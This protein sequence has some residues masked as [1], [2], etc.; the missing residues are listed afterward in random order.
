MAFIAVILS[1][2]ASRLYAEETAF[3]AADAGISKPGSLEEVVLQLK[4]KHQFQF[5]GYYA[6]VEKGYYAKAGLKVRLVEGGPGLDA[7]SEAAS[8][9]AQYGVS[10]SQALLHR[11]QGQPLVAL[12]AIFQHSP[13]VITAREDAGIST[14]QDLIGKRVKIARNSRDVEL[15]A[16]LMN[17][18]VSLDKIDIIDSW[19]R[20]EDYFDPDI[21][22]LSAYMTN[23]LFY[24][25]QEKI[26]H[27]IINPLVYGIDFYGDCLITSEQEL[28]E[29]P[30][31]V[32]AFLQASLD[33]WAYAMAHPDE[34]IQV[35][36]FKYESEK[37]LEHLQ[38]E[39]DVMRRL[40]MPDLVEIGHMN[41][42]RWK[43]IADNFAKFGWIPPDFSLEGF[44]YNPNPE[45][46]LAKLR[47]I[48][49][50]VSSIAVVAAL[51]SLILFTFLRRLGREAKERRQ[52]EETLRES[53][54]RYRTVAEYTYDWEYWQT[55][56]GL[57]PYI[58]PSCERITGYSAEEFRQ[59][60]DLLLAL[61]H[62]DDRGELAHHF[63]EQETAGTEGRRDIDFR[64]ITREGV[65]KW[66]AQASQPV[67]GRAGE[68]RGLRVSNRDVT[69]KVRAVEALAESEIKHKTMIANISDVIAVMGADGIIKYKT[70]NVEKWFGWRPEELIGRDGWQS[71]HPDDR[72]ELQRLFMEMIDKD[73][74]ALTFEFRYQC[75]NGEYK[76]VEM[77]AVNMV[78]DPNVNGFLMNYHDISDRKQAEEALEKR[79]I[80][81]TRP[82]DS[83]EGVAFEEMFSLT[84]IQEIQDMF[85][86]A[87]GVASILTDSDGAPLTKPSG[88][89]RLCNEIM[90]RL[91]RSPFT[92]L[93]S[94]LSP[95]NNETESTVRTCL[96]GGLWK[97]GARVIVGGRHIANW[98][99][100]QVRNGEHPDDKV[101]EYA[102]ELGADVNEF[103]EA[104]FEI[105]VMSKSKF[106]SAA[107]ALEVFARQLSNMAYQNIQQ[108]R[109]I[110][111]RKRAEQEK[112]KLQ[113]QLNQA[114]KME[115]IGTLAGGVS[116]DFNNLL[117]VINGF[118][119]LLL[120]N[121][122]ED[123][124]EYSKLEAINK[125][126]ERAAQLVR[127]LMLF[128]RKLEPERRPVNLNHEVTQAA[129]ML[130]RTIPRM[131]DIE[132]RLT[133]DLWM[134]K[135]DPVQIE[136]IILNLGG[137][138]ADAMPDG[139]T[140]TL[141]TEN[142]TIGEDV[143]R[144]L[145]FSG[146]G[147]FVLITAADTGLGMSRE[148]VEHIFEPFY[149]TKEIGKGTGLGLASVY[150]IVKSHGG[151]ILCDSA[152]GKGTVFRIYLPALK[153]EQNQDG[154]KGREITPHGGEEKIL[155]VDDDKDIRDFGSQILGKFGY[156][157]MTASS[158]EQAL[159]IY[160]EEGD[161]DLVVLDIGMPGMGGGKCLNELIRMD[162]QAKVLI[163][164][165]YSIAG[166]VKQA[167][168]EG[169]AGY[170]G[171]PYQVLDLLTKVRNILDK[172]K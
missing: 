75:K 34:I 138:A 121:R 10:N 14:P 15:H 55:P 83:P 66:I 118:T 69:E 51:I 26:P 106:Q 154:N 149:T 87:A 56:D 112:E 32:K 47:S 84:A 116:H 4:W 17:E 46:N 165:G 24:Y 141:S 53:E 88:F 42:G 74:S 152:V 91:G 61:V 90:P 143:F 115:A 6:A 50:L 140:L 12:A 31:R 103:M 157:V 20:R 62:P 170:V 9:R 166:Q 77:T 107:R 148:T 41:P 37:S 33:G 146:S 64:I 108:A 89:Y 135:A 102:V 57:L 93:D 120:L 13:L 86:E 137:N 70:P 81:L 142:A 22:A 98:I 1:L 147:D 168:N 71:V 113:T 134:V 159:A 38:F 104:F 44:I 72:E 128:S 35:V 151:Y 94:N 127:Q 96:N 156:D 25:I 164:S 109:F 30:E 163:A 67:Y 58:S 122:Q 63:K 52:V 40:I 144:S 49:Y 145:P 150:G 100:G 139:G 80:A 85:A 114:Q 133:D 48:I 111:D 129:A 8:G 43:H 73:R 16:A 36:R 29:H 136:Q 5:A 11:I 171:K 23:E 7:V 82:L 65:E 160:S 68:Y 99:I 167:L 153:Q 110:A 130:G 3:S 27:R 126:G 101:K 161:I 45:A 158:G 155:L 21:D 18:G 2:G 76:M 131:I 105:P 119:Q 78:N 59:D 92:C 28:N 117:Q 169:A 97:A 54:E 95:L 125:A 19:V 162:P 79:I 60:P 172:K 123:D 39:A 124:P 132:T